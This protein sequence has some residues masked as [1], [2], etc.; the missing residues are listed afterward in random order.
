M[1][2][3]LGCSTILYGGHSLN[4]ALQQ[5]SKI[6]YTAVE[7]C[8]IGGMAPHLEPDALDAEVVAIGAML[9][10]NDLAIESIGASGRIGDADIF[11]RLLD[12]AAA[13][14][15]PAISTG[16]PGKADDEDDFK[17][18]VDYVSKLG[19]YAKS[20]GVKISI[21]PHV[22]GS[23]YNTPTAARFMGEVDGDAIGLNWDASHIWRT[24]DEEDPVAS[25]KELAPHI[26]TLRIRDTLGREKPIGP[27]ANQIPGGGAL[28][29]ADIAAAMRD[30]PQTSHAVVEI[31]GT[32]EMS[33]DEV[34]DVAQRTYDGLSQYFDN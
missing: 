7:L 17:S 11:K 10:Q 22:G 15:A 27:V 1:G 8:S 21:K 34:N 3:E 32:K 24:D 29:L 30:V 2:L 14:G 23:V 18:A 4:T 28:P 25:V 19:E 5:I 31:V 13:L 33:F 16:P 9:R 26:T 20:V 12:I 6:G